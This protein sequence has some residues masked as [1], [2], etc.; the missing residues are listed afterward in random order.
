MIKEDKV[1]MGKRNNIQNLLDAVDKVNVAGNI[2]EFDEA[3][4]KLGLEIYRRSL[5]KSTYK[6]IVENSR[7]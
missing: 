6:I 1:K 5:R 2:T 3:C 4:Q 7:G